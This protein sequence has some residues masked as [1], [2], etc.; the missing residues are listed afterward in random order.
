[1]PKLQHTD[2]PNYISPVKEGIQKVRIVGTLDLT[3]AEKTKDAFAW[4]DMAV[5]VSMTPAN[6][7]MEHP[8]KCSVIANFEK[9]GAG[10]NGGDKASTEFLMMEW[11]D[12][13]HTPIRNGNFDYAGFHNK[14]VNVLVYRGKS[15]YMEVFPRCFPTTTD[16]AILRE[17]SAKLQANFIKDANRT[18]SRIEIA[19]D[20][21]FA[22]MIKPS[23]GSKDTST[24]TKGNGFQVE[25]DDHLQ[26]DNPPTGGYRSAPE[27]DDE[28]LP[29]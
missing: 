28:D 20:S 4:A 8:L 10:K 18:N 29:F 27:A 3:T 23:N 7:K 13:T 17:M 26:Q 15:G 21:M 22:G 2:A 16:E 24:G 9:K 6:V 11:V 1:M 25:E 19:P 5:E 14:E 12:S